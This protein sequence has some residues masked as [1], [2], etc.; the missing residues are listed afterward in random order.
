MRETILKIAMSRGRPNHP[1]EA[2]INEANRYLANE[3][4]HNERM[5]LEQREPF[6]FPCDFG[7]D[8]ECYPNFYSLSITHIMTGRRWIYEISNINGIIINQGGDLFSLMM[9]LKQINGRMVGFNNL[10]YDYPMLHLI[11]QRQGMISNQELYA[12][13]RS[14][15]DTDFDDRFK[16]MIWDNQRIVEQ[17]DLRSVHHFDNQAKMTSLKMLEFNMRSHNI[18][19]LPFDPNL[20]LT[21]P[22]ADIILSYND[23]DVDE[24]IKFYMHSLPALI[25]RDELSKRYGRNFNNHNDTKIGKDYFIMELE[26]GGIQVKKDKKI[27]QSK[28]EFINVCEVILPYVNF[29]RPEFQEIKQFFMNSVIDASKIKGFFKGVSATLDGFQFDFGAGGI[30]G[31]LHKTIVRESATHKLIDI[32]V[33]SYYPNIAIANKLFPEHLTELFCKLYYDLYKE[34]ASHSKKSAINA[35]LKLALNGVY[36]DSNN[37]FS[38]F[39]DPKY[40]MSITI[41][42]QLLL[43]MLAEQLMKIPNLTMVQINTDGLT[44]LCPNEYVDHTMKLKTWWENLT[45][46][47]LERAD[48]KA[49]FIRDVNSYMALTTEGKVKRIGAYAHETALENPATR[50]IGW[51][52]N[53]SA[54][55][56]PKAA[57]AALIHGT[58][59]TKFIKTHKDPF[60]FMLRTKVNRNSLLEY[61]ENGQVQYLQK[62]TRYHVATTGGSLIKIMKPT[63]K[64]RLKWADGDHYVHRNTGEY[65][66]VGTGKKPPSGMFDQVAFPE[67]EELKD[68]RIGINAGWLVQECNNMDDFKPELMNYDFYIQEAH[69]LVD[70]LF[71]NEVK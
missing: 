61:T 6:P 43:C 60:D 33:A 1:T 58:N 11:L 24:T 18:R 10:S 45:N 52:K 2:D 56:I 54:L 9:Y 35:M 25:F 15:I 23:H 50:E 59:I 34:R 40:T 36:G 39:L 38:V 29:E 47:E 57:E 37:E 67:L 8:E 69:K 53:Q 4:I 19:E 64:Q 49:M 12:K 46:L 16:N 62:I 70:D 51:H 71:L 26:K 14:L 20:Q 63:D 28:R 30:H 42:G 13:S 44:F 55:V 3:A 21:R 27:I 5:G 22:Q 66:V 68:N 17:I 7:Y 48:Y 32:D 65:K 41:N 31:S